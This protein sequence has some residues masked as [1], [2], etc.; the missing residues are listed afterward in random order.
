MKGYRN[1]TRM[2]YAR[3]HGYWVRFEYL[4]HPISKM[5][6]DGRYGGKRKALK[7]AIKYRNE[8][9]DTPPEAPRA[10]YATRPWTYLEGTSELPKPLWG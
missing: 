4:S 1:I 8:V 9:I 10:R 7:A 3:S 2:D 6:S 5:F